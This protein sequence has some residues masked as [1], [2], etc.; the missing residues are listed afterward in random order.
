[1]Y[2]GNLVHSSCTLAKTRARY[3]IYT[4]L[5]QIAHVTT[6][7]ATLLRSKG[8]LC[9]TSSTPSKG[10]LRVALISVRF[11]YPCSAA[12]RVPHVDVMHVDDDFVNF[13]ATP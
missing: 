13:A 3:R 5:T 6:V 8:I 11:L 12:R 4:S 10:T 7:C 2:D 1:M 9:V